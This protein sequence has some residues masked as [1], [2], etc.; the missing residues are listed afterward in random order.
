MS[1]TTTTQT[2]LTPAQAK[3]AIRAALPVTLKYEAD[4]VPWSQSR[5]SEGKKP[6]TKGR[7]PGDGKGHYPAPNLRDLN[8]NWIVTFTARG[9]QKLSTAYMQ[10]IAHIP[11]Y[12]PLAV[13]TVD[14]YETI[15]HTCE[16]GTL[17]WMGTNTGHTYKGKPLPKPD[18][19][20][21]IGCLCLDAEVLNYDGFEGWASDMGMDAD[22]RKAEAIYQACLKNA[23]ALRNLLGEGLLAQISELARQL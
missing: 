13:V 12:R 20:D 22:S 3:E 15:R 18:M 9:G 4:F 19:V 11:G 6:D 2:D 8:L 7:T 23:L 1:D 14:D 16:T 5:S 10:G 17:A 21:V